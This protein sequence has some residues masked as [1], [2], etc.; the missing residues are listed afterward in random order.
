MG[1]CPR[2]D[3]PLPEHRTAAEG[4]GRAAGDGEG[5]G[6]G[7]EAVHP[8][9]AQQRGGQ[10]QG[11]R[12][13]G[14]VRRGRGLQ[15]EWWGHTGRGHAVPV[16]ARLRKSDRRIFH[17][18]ASL[19]KLSAKVGSTGT[20]RCPGT[21]MARGGVPHL[22]T[23]PRCPRPPVLR[24]AGRVLE[25]AGGRAERVRPDAGVRQ[26]PPGPL[27]PRGAARRHA[28]GSSGVTPTARGCWGDTASG[29]G[30]VG[31]S[32]GWDRSLCC[33]RGPLPCPQGARGPCGGL[34]LAFRRL[35]TATS[36]SG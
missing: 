16:L 14:T 21:G 2:A 35:W 23:T 22:V 7:E 34:P 24:A 32:P 28:G 36:T 27:L 20:A 29:Q 5:A 15:R 18:K 25:A 9:P 26:C 11:G 3:V 13:G 19:Q 12:R 17:T 8:P 30:T 33:Q 1:T 4:A 31:V 10:G 6:Q